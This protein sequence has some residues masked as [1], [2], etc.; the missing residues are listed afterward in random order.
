LNGAFFVTGKGATSLTVEQ[1]TPTWFNT[2][3]ENQKV[4]KDVLLHF[5]KHYLTTNKEE[6][7]NEKP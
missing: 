2:L 7:E 3:L 6:R 5:K 1:K 4:S